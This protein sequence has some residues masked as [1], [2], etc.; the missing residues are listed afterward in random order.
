MIRLKQSVCRAAIGAL[1][2]FCIV[3]AKGAADSGVPNFAQVEP[4]VWRGGQPT[5]QGWAYLHSL[6]ITNVVKLNSEGEGSD[7]AAKKLGMKIYAAPI[8]LGEQLGLEKINAKE[9][10]KILVTVPAKGTFIHCEHGQDRT[11]VF[12]AM[13]RMQKDGWTKL[14]A[15]KEML[16]HGFHKELHG[17]WAF[18]QSVG[19][20]NK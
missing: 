19:A 7:A 10:D 4:G 5:D 8:S 16:T 9:L 17:L 12:V 14:D 20:T 11:G 18:W 2:T 15:E 13:W 1:L 6:G 3:C